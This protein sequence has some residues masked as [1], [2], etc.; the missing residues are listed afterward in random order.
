MAWSVCFY[1]MAFWAFIISFETFFDGFFSS[2]AGT[3]KTEK[4]NTNKSKA[5][6]AAILFFMVWTSLYFF[7]LPAPEARDHL[8]ADSVFLK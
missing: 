5:P 7:I 2:A 1:S 3:V 4:T 8:P 6:A